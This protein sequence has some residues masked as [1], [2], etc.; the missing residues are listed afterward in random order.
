MS[1]D[2]LASWMEGLEAELQSG[3]DALETAFRSNPEAMN[4]F[5]DVCATDTFNGSWT[6]VCKQTQGTLRDPVS[7]VRALRKALQV[8]SHG[9]SCLDSG[10]LVASC[11]VVLTAPTPAKAPQAETKVRTSCNSCLSLWLSSS[12]IKAAGLPQAESQARMPQ[13]SSSPNCQWFPL[14]LPLWC[15]N[16]IWPIS[17]L[18]AASACSLHSSGYT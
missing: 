10:S 6:Q 3:V 17:V 1:D 12:A 2:S 5:M 7:V 13:A 16:S 14:P 4:R 9:A 18:G 15:W 11:G 8:A